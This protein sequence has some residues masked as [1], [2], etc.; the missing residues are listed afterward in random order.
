MHTDRG[1]C[2]R[3]PFSVEFWLAQALSKARL[4]GI[5]AGA[6]CGAVASVLSAADE[7]FAIPYGPENLRTA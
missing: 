5:Y 6:E 3:R 2:T 4:I 1:V 7:P